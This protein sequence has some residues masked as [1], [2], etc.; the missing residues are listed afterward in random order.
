VKGPVEKRSRRSQALQ[1]SKPYVS[2]YPGYS[3]YQRVLHDYYR[4]PASPIDLLLQVEK[5]TG[6]IFDPCCGGGTIPARCRA[7]GY[8]ADG[9]DLQDI[10]GCTVRDVF[11]STE[12]RD[13]HMLNPPYKQAERIIRHLLP[14]TRHKLAVLLRTNFL[15]GIKRHRGFFPFVP[16][17][18]MWFLSPRPSCPPG[19][20][21]GARDNL[22]CL[23]QPEETGGKMDYSRFIFERRHT[24]P[25]IGRPLS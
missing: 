6:S 14:L 24:G 21:Q 22:G 25:W 7:H 10:A 15:H 19:I 3:G 1:I 17:A 12:M 2:S 8:Q 16:L 18:R 4:E 23:I 20:Y 11:A 13:N 5:F 9:S